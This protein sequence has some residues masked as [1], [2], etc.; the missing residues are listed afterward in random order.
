MAAAA[1]RRWLSPERDSRVLLALVLLVAVCVRVGWIAYVNVD[2]EDGRLDDSLFYYRVA[3]ALAA[4]DGYLDPFL[5]EP[6]TGWPPAYTSLLALSFVVLRDTLIAT[7]VLNV[8]LAAGAVWLTYLLGRRLFDTRVGLVSAF[9]IAIFPSY[10]YLSTLAMA[11]NLFV[12]LFL[13][14]LLLIVGRGLAAGVAPNAARSLA[15]GATIALAA[16]T[17]AE[18][19]W[20]FLPAVVVWAVASRDRT[21]A[22]RSVCLVLVGA[23]IVFTP[24]TVRN[25]VQLG[26]FTVVRE[27]SS[28]TIA[29]GLHPGYRAY[30]GF[31]TPEPK[32]TLSDDWRIYRND[33]DELLTLL[34]HKMR[35]LYRDD[36][37]TASW[38]RGGS[39]KFA[40]SIPETQRLQAAANAA[41]FGLGI[42]A[43]T[44]LALLALARDRRAWFCAGVLLTWTLGFALLT[45]ESRYHL[46]LMPLMAILAAA[47]PAA[48]GR[49]VVDRAAFARHWHLRPL[50]TVAT[51]V[52]AGALVA[53]LTL[54]L[55]LRGIVGE[56][57]A[58]EIAVRS[59]SLGQPLTMDDLE[60]T[61]R[62]FELVPALGD[63]PAPPGRAW[64]LVE[65]SVRNLGIAEILLFGSIQAAVEDGADNSYVQ[66]IDASPALPLDGT[67]LPGE[68]LAA[69]AAYDVPAG[70]S[71]LQFVFKSVGTPEEGRWPLQ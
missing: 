48:A 57:K 28:G 10:V 1:L 20:L 35:D 2:P 62:G 52:T 39:G 29:I 49:A 42:I 15:L 59:A 43:V 41:Y 63:T 12:P 38:V 68:T 51:T 69:T 9:V 5:G 58:P 55:G 53:A 11:E 67:L 22:A 17:R 25:V 13:L 45:P 33:P 8:A 6:T 21:A 37:G 19:I 16:L 40:L 4:G 61:V 56:W 23:G 27:T 46:P 32:P 60:I 24:W 44:S 50:A 34:R 70:A 64:L 65:A 31:I 54:G 71:G 30:S 7:K 18:G 3:R 36:G 14:V 47:L 66:Q 26:E